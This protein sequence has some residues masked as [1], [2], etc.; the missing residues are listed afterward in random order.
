MS[1]WI[2]SL[3]DPDW[4]RIYAFPMRVT[5]KSKEMLVIED[6]PW[7]VAGVVW[8]LGLAAISSVLTGQ[9]DG[10]GET[11]LVLAL[12]LG[13]ATIAWHFLPFQRIEFDRTNGKFT[14]KIARVTGSKWEMRSLTTIRQAASQGDW[15]EGG[16]RMERVALLTDDGPYPLEYGFSGTSR[17]E[18]IQAINSWLDNTD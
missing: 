13:A 3:V 16:T 2:V 7:F 15:S 10:I 12:G 4:S 9:M 18:V 17:A 5:H 14:R 8:F 6:R 1:K 11:I